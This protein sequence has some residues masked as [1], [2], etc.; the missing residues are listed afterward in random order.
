M[1]RIAIVRKKDCNPATCGE[2]LCKKL[3]PINRAGEPC[4]QIGEDGKAEID[5]VL[6]TGCG[7]CS[8][9]CPFGAIDII[10]LPAEL[11]QDP[12]HRY[13]HNGFHLYNLPIPI[14]GKVVGVLGVNG[15]GKSTAINILAGVLK[16]NMGK[17]KEASYQDLIEFYKGSEAQKFFEKIRDGEIK[18]ALKPQEVDKIPKSF[19][20]T[21]RELLEK[22]DEKKELEK[23]S[24]MLELT[25]ILNRDVK[26]ISGGE[27]QRVAIAAT[28]LKKANLY[29]F[30]EPTSYLDIKQ[31][32]KISKF[33]KEL[34]DE[35][36]A[37]LVIEHDL[38]ILD[39]LTDL[40][41]I[42][43][44]KQAAY[45][46]V[47]QPKSTRVGINVYL[48]GYLKEENVRFRPNQ[49][50]FEVRPEE[51][52]ENKEEVVN[53]NKVDIKLG[54]FELKAK[55]GII[56]R[57]DVIGILGENGI[58]KTSFVKVLAKEIK[59]DSV[60]EGEIKIAYKPQYLE[61]SDELVMQYLNNAIM[62]HSS[63]LIKPLNVEP[64]LTKQLNQLSGGELQKVCIIK[65]LAED[66]DLYL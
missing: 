41:H 1:T 21:V 34:A 9:R 48:S 63:Q 15:I 40:I 46:I 52:R 14:F 27:L 24:E 57:H 49:I 8:N 66:A 2:Y 23:I 5:E 7:I 10:K 18:V 36:T 37:V 51:K 3:C 38:I 58:G 32:L 13:G 6:C 47:S 65:T 55:K 39:F 4:I 33:L 20:G 22:V 26:T 44:G 61:S 28:V 54:D 12:I 35:N 25:K 60:I 29:I 16:P 50:K 56:H 30:D 59:S 17:E 31:R 11:T 43:Y 45:G 42:M 64:L 62:H 19:D 53:W